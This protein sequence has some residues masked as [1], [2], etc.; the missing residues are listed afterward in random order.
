MVFTQSCWGQHWFIQIPINRR[1][2]DTL[3]TTTTGIAYEQGESQIVMISAVLTWQR[4]DIAMHAFLHSY[5]K[6]ATSAKLCTINTSKD[7]D[8]GLYVRVQKAYLAL[9]YGS[10]QGG[11]FEVHRAGTS[12]L[13]YNTSAVPRL[14]AS[15]SVI[16]VW[17]GQCWP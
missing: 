14:S 2:A 16:D 3:G 4:T 11:R 13:I 17:S 1:P 7:L 12:H 6:A 8:P 15:C 10:T 9:S 5:I